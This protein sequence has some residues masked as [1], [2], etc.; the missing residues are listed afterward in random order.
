MMTCDIV[1]TEM[2]ANIFG[3]DK[4]VRTEKASNNNNSQISCYSRIKINS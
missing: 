3:F 4:R 2:Q 1:R